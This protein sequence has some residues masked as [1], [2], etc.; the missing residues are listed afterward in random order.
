[1]EV[2]VESARGDAAEFLADVRDASGSVGAARQ[3]G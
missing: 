2:V 3:T 1:M